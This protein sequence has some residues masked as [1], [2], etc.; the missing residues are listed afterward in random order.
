LRF[1]D[2]GKFW[3]RRKALERRR[4]HGMGVDNFRV[5]PGSSRI[6]VN[7]F[8]EALVNISVDQAKKA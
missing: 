5:A 8:E 3:G 2:L 7:Y 6:T 1:R 4:E